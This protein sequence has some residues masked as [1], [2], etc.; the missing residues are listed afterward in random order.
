[1]AEYIQVDLTKGEF[2]EMTGQL[3]RGETVELNAVDEEGEDCLVY[4]EVDG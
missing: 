1:M 4:I 2:V 3:E